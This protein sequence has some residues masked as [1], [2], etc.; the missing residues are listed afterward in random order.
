[1]MLFKPEHVPHILS[2]R[3]TQTRRLGKK[4][5]NVGAVHQ[6]QT[7]MLRNDSVFAHVRILDVR[8]ERLR[9]MR[10]CDIYAEGYDRYSEYC[11]ALE[12]ING[13]AV[14]G[15]TEVWVVEFALEPEATP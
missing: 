12:R 10:P 1:M 7:Q 2:G 8:R 6:C 4:R 13:V 15:D 11:E 9:D 3:K 14:D 5:W